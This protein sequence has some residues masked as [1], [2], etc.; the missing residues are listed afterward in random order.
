MK[1][2]LSCLLAVSALLLTSCSKKSAP[3]PP[4]PIRPVTAAKAALKDVPVYLEEIGNCSAYESVLIQPQVTGPIME[5]RF[6]DGMELK[7][8]DIL[9]MID[10]RPYQAAL[11]KAKATLEQDRAKLDF[12]DSQLRRNQELQRTKVIAAQEFD[13][14]RSLA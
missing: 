5:I 1:S 11:D 8:G 7:K 3:T 13:N 10:P 14:A 6:T 2:F 4:K 9:F 12:A